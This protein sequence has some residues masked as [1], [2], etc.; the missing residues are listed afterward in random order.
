[1]YPIANH[2]MLRHA[3][4]VHNR[5]LICGRV[6]EVLS[7]LSVRENYILRG[8]VSRLNQEYDAVQREID[9]INEASE[10]HWSGKAIKLI[11]H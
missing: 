8:E 1:M 10:Q 6:M 9:Y 4:L 7:A 3:A 2:F 5:K 11:T